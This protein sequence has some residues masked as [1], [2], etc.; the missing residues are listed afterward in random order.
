MSAVQPK[1]PV[2]GAFGVF[3]GE[4]RAE[5][6]KACEGKPVSEV[7]KMAGEEWKKLSEQDRKPYQKKYEAAKQQYDQD[8]ATFLANGGTKEK[9]AAALRKDAMKLKEAKKASKD[10]DA[11][12]RPAGGAYGQFLAEKREE[13]KK[14][15]PAGHSI[16]DVAKKAGEM[17]K[18]LP[19]DGR[20]KFE[21]AYK[22]AQEEYKRQ[23]EVYS[24]QKMDLPLHETTTP[25]KEAAQKRKG[26]AAQQGQSK[27]G[28][29]TKTSG[30]E[31]LEFSE[32]VLAKARAAGYEAQF[33]N[34][35]SRPEI[36]ATGSSPETLLKALVTSGGLVNP[37][38]QALLA[39]A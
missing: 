13:I 24:A 21:E 7:S 32:E 4:K 22:T 14:S 39:G 25:P 18:S 15:L 10:K 31:G 29:Q 11:P 1:K 20:Q 38:K 17:W 36:I 33:Q 28:R 30:K 35:A 19:A 9:G 26:D 3:V 8:L 16:T 6:Q 5:F 2:G 23:M 12:K 37:A 27:R 34:L